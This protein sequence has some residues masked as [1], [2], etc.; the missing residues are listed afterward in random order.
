M[1]IDSFLIYLLIYLIDSKKIM[2]NQNRYD[3][4]DIG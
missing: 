3:Q 1:Y 4:F 2:M